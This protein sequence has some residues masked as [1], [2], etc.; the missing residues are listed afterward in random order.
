MSELIGKFLIARKK[1]MSSVMSP[2]FLR[3]ETKT[4]F[5]VEKYLITSAYKSTVTKQHHKLTFFKTYKGIKLKNVPPRK[6][7]RDVKKL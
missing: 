6:R 7:G 2:L 1:I 4:S 3:K 5:Y